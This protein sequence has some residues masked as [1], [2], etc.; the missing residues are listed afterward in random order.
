VLCTRSSDGKS[1][2]SDSSSS[3][4]RNHQG[5]RGC[6]PDTTA[7]GYSDRL[8]EVLL[9]VYLLSASSPA[10]NW[11]V[12]SRHDFTAKRIHRYVHCDFVEVLTT[13]SILIIL[14]SCRIR[15]NERCGPHQMVWGTVSSHFEESQI[16]E[17]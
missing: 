1:S 8:D 15:F 7:R 5:G 17:S 14:N 10:Q 12:V 4:C 3:C 2:V 6:R 9:S 16:A 13:C 11:P